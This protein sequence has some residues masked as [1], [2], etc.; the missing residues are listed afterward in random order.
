MV[1]GDEKY[2]FDGGMGTRKN[3]DWEGVSDKY[4]DFSKAIREAY[5]W[6]KICKN[7]NYG[8]I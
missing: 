7:R 6:T 5:Q 1:E 3:G 8:R 4:W 2:C